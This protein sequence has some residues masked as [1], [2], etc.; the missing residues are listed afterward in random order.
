MLIQTNT[1]GASAAKV[2]NALEPRVR[3][4]TFNHTSHGSVARLPGMGQG[5]RMPSAIT[6]TITNASG[7]PLTYVLGEAAGGIIAGAHGVVWN[8]PTA[9]RGNNVA[10]VQDSFKATPVSVGLINYEALT[11][12]QFAN[13]LRFVRGDVNGNYGG[14]VINIDLARRNNQQVSTLQTLDFS[15]S[16]YVLDSFH[17]FTLVV[18]D[19]ETVTFTL[20][21]D[22]AVGR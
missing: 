15:D 18:N 17:A 22:G 13:P 14:D 6:Y 7:G 3:T 19:G 12:A 10:A 9:I 5:T 1:R 21:I 4:R 20:G 8:Q 2:A 11:V 16:P